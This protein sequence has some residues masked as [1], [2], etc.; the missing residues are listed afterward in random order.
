[1][2]KSL[3]YYIAGPMSNI[4]QFNFPAFEHAAQTLR[5]QGFTIISP[6][7]Q[8]T[9]EVQKAAWASKDGKLDAAGKVAG[10]TWGQILSKDVELVADK[11][12]GIIFLD[13][14]ILS[15][16]AKLEAFVGL[17]TGKKFGWFDKLSGTALEKSAAGVRINIQGNMP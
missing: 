13:N 1:M 16:G 12:G 14:W 8:D 6:H 15:R 2:D 5:A 17:L 7:E 3:V 4:P 11:I 9:P 10:L